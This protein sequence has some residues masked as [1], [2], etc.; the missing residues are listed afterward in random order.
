MHRRSF[1]GLVVYLDDFLIVARS[2][3]ECTLAFETLLG[4]LT[5]LGFQISPSKLVASC[6][7]LTLCCYQ[8]LSH[9]AVFAP[10][11]A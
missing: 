8:H 6:Q 3:E 2:K 11:Q 7:Q 10:R 9:G 5:D 4:L 1:D